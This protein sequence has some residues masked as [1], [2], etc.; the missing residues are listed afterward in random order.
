MADLSYTQAVVMGLLQGVTELFPV[1]SLGHSLLV[2]AW[3]GGSWQKLVTESNSAG[4]TPFLAFI[5]AL[6]VA[7]AVALILFYRRDWARVVTGFVRS[8]R[9]RRIETSDERLAWMLIIGTV[10]VGIV[11]L[12]AEHPLREVFATPLAAAIF[13]FLNGGLLFA[14]ERLRRRAVG[15]AGRHH[16]ASTSPD[17]VANTTVATDVTTRLGYRG[18]AIVGACQILALLPGIS[19]SGATISGGILRGLDHEDAAKFAFLLATP[20]IL[21]A[22][23]LKLPELFGPAGH[24]IGGQTLVGSACAFAAALGAV[25]FLARFFHTRTL[26]PFVVYCLVAGAISIV[27]FA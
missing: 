3:I 18:A 9:N 13:L 19:R 4:H 24:G 11:G 6:H 21:A 20:V 15:G 1:S 17:T 16:V 14:A 27:R 10:P 25:G 12:V 7:T 22:G 5:V 8:V 2:P 23:V 26:Y